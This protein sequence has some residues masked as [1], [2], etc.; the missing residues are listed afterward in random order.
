MDHT[1]IET[2]KDLANYLRCE[3]DFL[4]DAINNEYFLN[5]AGIEFTDSQSKIVVSKFDI[6]KKSKSGGFRT[7]YHSWSY[8]LSNTLKILNTNLNGIFTHNPFSHGFVK[9]KNI[10]TNASCHLNKRLLLSVDFEHYFES[11]SKEMVVKGL[12]KIGFKPHI[13]NCISNIVTI[14]NSLP[15]GFATS[16]T[17]ANIVTNELD[18]ELSKLCGDQIVYSRYADDLYFSTNLKKI[19]LKEITSIIESYDFSLNDKKT[20]FMSRGKKQYVTGLTVFDAEYPRIS[21]RRK[22]NIRLEIYFLSKFGYKRHIRKKLIKS[23]INPKDPNFKLYVN[24]EIDVT[25]EKLYGWLHFINAIE[26]DFAKKYYAKLK[27][28]KQ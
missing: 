2:L 1:E 12:E 14:N 28:A 9:G 13:A 11:V 3:I 21:K 26:P 7:V 18:Y 23:G 15:Q 4:E 8:F 5:S 19:P 25:R 22:K 27:S 6:P 10:Q 16:P 24:D 17:L 20:K